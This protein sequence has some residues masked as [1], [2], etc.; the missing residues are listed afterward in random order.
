MLKLGGNILPKILDPTSLDKSFRDSA[1]D[2]MTSSVPG[3]F[4]KDTII[5]GYKEVLDYFAGD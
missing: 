3:G 1:I 4:A 2:V 5:D